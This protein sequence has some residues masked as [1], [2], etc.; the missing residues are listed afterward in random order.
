MNQAKQGREFHFKNLKKQRKDAG[1]LRIHV[2]KIEQMHSF[3]DFLKGGL[4]ISM[5]N[6]IDFTGSN[7]EP[8]QPSSL[9]ARSMNS[10]NQYQNAMYHVGHLL[11]NYDTDKMI[12]TYGFGAV[13]NFPPPGI[14][15]QGTSHF[16]PCSGQWENTEGF[17]VDG[18]FR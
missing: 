12:P 3:Y 15:S 6:C 10:M 1:I 17:G 18:I 7:G 16:F 13:C 5:V 4:N 8:Q 14:T 9:H 2:S 11:C